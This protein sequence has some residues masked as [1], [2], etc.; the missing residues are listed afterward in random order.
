MA[1]VSSYSFVCCH[2]S[3]TARVIHTVSQFYCTPQ[4]ERVEYLWGMRRGSRSVLVLCVACCR[5]Q[6]KPCLLTTSVT[7]IG[8][9]MKLPPVH[10]TTGSV[11]CEIY[12]LQVYVF[13]FSPGSSAEFSSRTAF[14]SSSRHFCRY[15]FASRAAAKCSRSS[16]RG[17][18]TIAVF[19]LGRLLSLLY[20][21]NFG[22]DCGGRSPRVALSGR[23]EERCGF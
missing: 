2:C 18:L 15:L 9:R 4:L 1:R 8:K 7:A 22:T 11:T 14:F 19:L 10:C 17:A 23:L 12:L 21:Q 5:C 20:I 16:F 3:R 6:E 13:S